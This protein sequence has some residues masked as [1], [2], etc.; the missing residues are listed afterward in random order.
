M[1]YYNN[2]DTHFSCSI[3]KITSIFTHAK[4]VGVMFILQFYTA[5]INRS[6]NNQL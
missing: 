4:V 6:K 1:I 3:V 5:Y 2:A